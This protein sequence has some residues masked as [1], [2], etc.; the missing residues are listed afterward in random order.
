MVKKMQLVNGWILSRTEKEDIPPHIYT[1]KCH[2]PSMNPVRKFDIVSWAR[3]CPPDPQKSKPKSDWV[4]AGPAFVTPLGKVR[5]ELCPLPRRHKQCPLRKRVLPL[6]LRL[7]I[8]NG[9][10]A[11]EGHVACA[12]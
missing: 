1:N 6:H 9:S 10:H 5:D 8:E 4:A 2:M 3:F 11:V 7:L 12:S